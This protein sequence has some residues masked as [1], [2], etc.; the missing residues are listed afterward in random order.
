[1]DKNELL[2]MP[3]HIAFIMDGNGRWAQQQGLPRVAGHT[4]GGKTFRKI[5]DACLDRDIEVITFFAFSTENWKRPKA[6]V[7]GL[8]KLLDHYLEDW[9]SEQRAKNTRI[10]FLGDTTAFSDTEQRLIA[11]AE[12]TGEDIRHHLNIALNYGGR[13]DITRAANRLLQSRLQTGDASP[14][15]EEEIASHLAT[16]SM[17]DVDLL[18]RTGGER[19]IS[20][21]L[22]WQSAYAELYFCDTLWP[23]FTAEHL[24]C[25]IEW[26]RCRDRR[27]GGLN[28][29]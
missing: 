26:Y 2:P 13:A 12:Q 3:R 16:A 20:N 27:Y 11:A 5:C 10:H 6:E 1:M 25:A 8:M 24:D 22:L 23:D 17:P 4:Q 18:I 21:F 29:A 14:V 9:F 19:R 28:P 7:A 15:S